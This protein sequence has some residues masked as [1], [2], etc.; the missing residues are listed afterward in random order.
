M[1]IV[2]DKQGRPSHITSSAAIPVAEFD[3][4][5]DNTDQGP[6]LRLVVPLTVEQAVSLLEVEEQ[7]E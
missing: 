7:D 1:K 6:V 5:L 3:L 2:V 4:I